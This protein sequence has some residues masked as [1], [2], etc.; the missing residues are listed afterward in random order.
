LDDDN[1][2]VRDLAYWHLDK[3]GVA[4][5]LP[6]EAKNIDYKPTFEREQR[7][8]AIEQWNKLI[9]EGKVPVAPG[10]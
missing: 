1:Q 9:R 5:L 10:R 2:Q 6:P 8:P 4:G 7:R 3:L